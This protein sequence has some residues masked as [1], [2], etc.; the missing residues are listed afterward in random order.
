METEIDI[1]NVEPNVD[2][3]DTAPQAIIN[4]AIAKA[5]AAFEALNA[6]LLNS[7]TE[8]MV[9][10]ISNALARQ[11]NLDQEDLAEVLLEKLR[12]EIHTVARPEALP[13]WSFRVVENH[14]KNVFKHSKVVKRHE[15]FVE[16][17]NSGGKR[18]SIPV[19]KSAALNPEEQLIEKE[20]EPIWDARMLETRAKV[21]RIII[22]DVIIA[23]SWG[24][25]QRPEVIAEEIHKSVAT[26]YRK[27]GAI[28][29]AVIEEIGLEETDENKGLIKEGLRELFV[30]SLQ[31][32]S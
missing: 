8:E 10:R 24:K 26:V 21:R 28:Q 23:S 14:C 22:E 13:A 6:L 7:W 25:G 29:K 31:G 3:T 32:L 4:E 20:E 27:L 1:T 2:I 18:N 16:H 9:D 11:F 30:N 12:F 17:V 15:D 5:K 19:A